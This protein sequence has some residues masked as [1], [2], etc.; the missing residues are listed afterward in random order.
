MSAEKLCRNCRLWTR[1]TPDEP[2]HVRMI[3]GE[4]HL[5]AAFNVG[6]GHRQDTNEHDFCDQWRGPNGERFDDAPQPA[7]QQQRRI[8]VVTADEL[9]GWWQNRRTFR[10]EGLGDTWQALLDYFR[11]PIAPIEEEQRP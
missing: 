1:T 4:C 9:G 8:D 10:V 2:G 11:E 6:T 7:P 3:N 5:A